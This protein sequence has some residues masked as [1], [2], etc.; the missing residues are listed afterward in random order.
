MV[1]PN[2]PNPV[3]PPMPHDTET[4][5]ADVLV[6]KRGFSYADAYAMLG[7][8]ASAPI[9]EVSN[10]DVLDASTPSGTPIQV[11]LKDPARIA[12]ENQR[13]ADMVKRSGFRDVPAPG[14]PARATWEAGI[15][16]VQQTL[17]GKR[18]Q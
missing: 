3:R 9:T 4:T 12:A 18:T 10:P 11:D 16:Q 8:V 17:H 14:D 6:D 7:E 1:N 15:A 13:Q 5:A 2:T